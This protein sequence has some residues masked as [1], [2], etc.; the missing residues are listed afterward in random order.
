[1]E[2]DILIWTSAHITACSEDK[3]QSLYGRLLS[4]GLACQD[5]PRTP[6]QQEVKNSGVGEASRASDCSREEMVSNA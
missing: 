2:V 6:G 1:M 5:R 4:E 3:S